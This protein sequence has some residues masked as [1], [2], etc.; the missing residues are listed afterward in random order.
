MPATELLVN[1]EPAETRVALIEEG[2]VTELHVERAQDRSIVGNIYFGRVGRVL[3]GMQAAFVDIGLERHAFLQVAD[4]VRPEDLDDMS[5]GEASA[6]DMPSKRI[7]K[8]TPISQ[9]LKPGQDVVVQVSRAPIDKKGAR[10]T[11]HVSLAGRHLVFLPTLEQ[12]GV[13]RRIE[14]E[15]ERRRLRTAVETLRTTGGF[16]VRTVAE[17]VDEAVLAKD[18]QYLMKLW[19]EVLERRRRVKPPTLLHG[20]LDLVLRGARDLLN[21]RVR[22]LVVDDRDTYHRVRRYAETFFEDQ[23]EKVTLYT[24]DEPIFDAF[25]IEEEVQRA[26]SRVIPLPSGGTLV[27]DHAEALTAI[28]VNS[29]RFSGGKDLEE[30]ITQTNLEAVKE[31]TYQLRLRNIGGL[32]VVDFI[33]MDRPANREKVNKALQEALKDDRAQTTAVRIS[34]LGLVEMTRKGSNQSLGRQLFEP[35]F[36]CG[37]TGQLKSRTTISGSILREVGKRALELRSPSIVI[38]C[39]PSVAEALTTQKELKEAVEAVEHRYSK[40]VHIK[41][42]EDFHFERYDIKGGRKHGTE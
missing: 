12:I 33:D 34:E 38:E 2:L 25:G 17:G 35:C 41:A 14:D 32:I 7:N 30:T 10:V 1:V 18:V 11:S 24:G 9:V 42:R 20:D 29:G 5:L 28:D 36:Y 6:E 21:A 15:E 3:A 39:H 27:F 22:R 13:S 23:L 8:N 16:I 37:G 31:V 40:D 19:S 26:M 4:T